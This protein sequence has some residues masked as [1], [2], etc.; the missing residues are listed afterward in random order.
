MEG[1]RA[2][3]RCGSVAVD[4]EKA[5]QRIISNAFSRKAGRRAELRATKKMTLTNNNEAMV[6]VALLEGLSGSPREL[7]NALLQCERQL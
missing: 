4:T 7:V 1:K 6:A 3:A 5:G 2:H